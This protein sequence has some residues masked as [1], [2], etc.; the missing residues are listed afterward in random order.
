M[1]TNELEREMMRS[2]R[3]FK[4]FMLSCGIELEYVGCCRKMFPLKHGAPHFYTPDF[5]DR[6]KNEYYEVKSSRNAYIGSA[7]TFA[8][9]REQY[10]GFILHI[11]SPDGRD[12][13][14][15][16]RKRMA[17]TKRQSD[18]ERGARD[19]WQMALE[20]LFQ[21]DPG[22]DIL[23]QIILIFRR[24]LDEKSILVLKQRLHVAKADLLD[25]GR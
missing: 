6:E 2:E 14:E 16:S 24:F 12:W 7:L 11:V 25:G 17:P 4:N 1:Q 13:I 5:Y 10:P 22:A 23:P 21:V 8:K 20:R 18:Y 9:F 3:I 15:D 19:A